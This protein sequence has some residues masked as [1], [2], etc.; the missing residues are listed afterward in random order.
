MKKIAFVFTHVPHGSSGGREGLDAVLAT[1]ALT[2]DIGLFFLSDGVFQLLPDQQP[3][4]ILMRNY[5]ATFGVLALY[6]IEQCFICSDSM[7][8]RGIDLDA[9]LVIDAIRLNQQQIHDC[10]SGYD[11]VLTF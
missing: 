3:D 8:V 5:I 7:H 9:P 2:D 4:Q 1:S 10:L 11:V 6:D